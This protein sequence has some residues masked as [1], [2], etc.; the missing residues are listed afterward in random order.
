MISPRTLLSLCVL[1]LALPGCSFPSAATAAQSPVANAAPDW[2]DRSLYRA[3]LVQA[4]RPVLDGLAGATVYALDLTIQADLVHVDWTESV[5]YTNRSGGALDEIDLHLFPNLLGGKLSLGAVDANGKA[6]TPVT[7]LMD[8]LLRV[9]L[10]PPLPAG[11]VEDLEIAFNLQVPT[12]LDAGYGVLASTGGVLTLAHSYPTVAVLGPGGWDTELPS[13]WGD[14]LNNEMC[15]YLV[16]VDAP[17]DLTLVATGRQVDSTRRGDRQQVTFADGPA[18]DFFLAASAGFARTS[19]TV[20]EVTVNSYAPQG[21]EAQSR[22]A[23][24]S[25]AAALQDFSGRYAAYPYTEYDLV[26]VPTNALGIEYPGL[27]AIL[28]GLYASPTPEN[29][30]TLEFTVVHETG[31]QWFYNLVG[32]NQLD[33]PWLDESLAQFVTGQYY[34]DRYGAAAAQIFEQQVFQADWN[35]VQDANLPIGKPVRAYTPDQY[36]GIVYGRGPLFFQALEGQI[37]QAAFDRFLRDYTTRY[38][39]GIATGA[40][41]QRVAELDCGCDLTSIFQEWVNP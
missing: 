34:T 4:D 8:S 32:D 23:L 33:E 16:R 9:P 12:N 14:M 27:V 30:R 29:Q 28:G 35:V 11:Q 19:R 36:L 26:S 22:L 17:A 21:D 3:G 40:G 10:D 38:A 37:G 39:W 13:P 7:S 20:G 41:L 31:H 15:F 25:A 2:A 18:R 1:L 24:D 5:H 6:V